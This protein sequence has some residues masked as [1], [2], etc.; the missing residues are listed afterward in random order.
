M[1]NRA[2]FMLSQRDK[3]FY[4]NRITLNFLAKVMRVHKVTRVRCHYTRFTSRIVRANFVRFG[5]EGQVW[6]TVLLVLIHL[7]LVLF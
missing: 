3:A 1:R 2:I 6:R 5:S 7:F 4:F